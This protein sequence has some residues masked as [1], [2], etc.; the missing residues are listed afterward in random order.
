MPSKDGWDHDTDHERITLGKKTYRNM[1]EWSRPCGVCG[2]RFSIYVRTNA[3]AVNSSFGLKTCK[4]HRGQKIGG[5]VL[6][7]G[8]VEELRAELKG[9]QE[10]LAEWSAV[11]KTCH[12]LLKPYG[13]GGV[14]TFARAVQAMHARLAAYELPAAMAQAE[15]G[16]E[17][18]M[19]WVT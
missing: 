6:D 15:A 17:K 9:M 3:T 7:S 8:A 11:W 5:G 2:T 16:I 19:P 13:L 14:D 10:L 1:E 12:P 18:K 4:E